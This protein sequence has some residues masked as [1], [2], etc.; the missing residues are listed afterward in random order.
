MIHYKLGFF[1]NLFFS[2]FVDLEIAGVKFNKK[3]NVIT[4]DP[5]QFLPE[6]ERIASEDFSIQ[7]FS[8]EPGLLL[9]RLDIMATSNSLNKQK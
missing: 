1:K 3:E 2:W 8:L 6:K 4:I 9:I 5:F 7:E